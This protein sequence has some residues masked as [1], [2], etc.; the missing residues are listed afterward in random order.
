MIFLNPTILF[1]LLAASI[2]I[3]LHFLNLR[4]IKKVE[5]STLA[6]LKELQKSKIRK[7]KI[8]QLLLL[9][10]RILI[11]LFL[12]ASFARPTLESTSLGG[13]ASKAKTT[14]IFI[15]DNS[16]SMSVVNENGSYFNHAKEQ[17]K[18]IIPS[19]ESGDEL[20]LILTSDVNGKANLL[21][22]S[23]QIDAVEISNV[24]RPFVKSIIVAEEI[25]KKSDNF[26]KEIFIFS[27]FQQSTFLEKDSTNFKFSISDT[28]VYLS[29]YGGKNITNSSLSNTYFNNQI[30]ELNKEIN[31]TSEVKTTN[32][33]GSEQL[34]SL[35]FNGKRVA[36][37][38]IKSVKSQ[39]VYPNFQATIESTGLIEVLTE[40]EED[41]I[42]YD[43][44]YFSHFI[45]PDNI[46]L[47]IVRNNKKQ[48]GFIR[49]ALSTNRTVKFDEI[50]PSEFSNT[51]LGSYNSLIIVGAEVNRNSQELKN[52]LT[53]GG[54][55]LLFPKDNQLLSEIN[56]L[57]YALNLP[58]IKGIVELRNRSA[59]NEFE[60][61]DYEHPIFNGLFTESKSEVESPEIYKYLKFNTSN[62][63]RNIISLQDNS[64]F[65]SEYRVGKGKILFFGVSPTLVWSSFPVK[66]IFAPLINRSVSYLNSKVNSDEKIYAG[67]IIDVNISKRKSEQIEVVKP[68]KSREL[69]N[70]SFEANNYLKYN[71]SSMI[72]NYKF[73]SNNELLDVKSVNVNPSESEL[74]M[75]D[76]E[77]FNKKNKKNKKNNN[78]VVDISSDNYLQ[79]ITSSR[80]GSELWKIFLIIALL[81]AL[82][83]M[84]IA[85]SAKKD[86]VEL[87]N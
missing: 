67:D 21:E 51:N 82:V 31:V 28:K 38:N 35:F 53:D 25:L 55:V 40:I 33:K 66:N 20:F 57:T 62:N 36:Q 6:F 30:F 11:I 39:N 85:R 23:K 50:L 13:V 43:N 4:K 34:V 46:K 70:H 29:N 78:S 47:L 63:G 1:G 75:I 9:L 22:S 19:F 12:V 5:F 27:D 83:E 44:R 77:S 15:L 42:E 54:N 86:L 84:Y 60:K 61:I 69:I 45:V 41:L 7:I 37:K 76:L 14:A 79:K 3:V 8:K 58:K 64:S 49:A 80:Y 81:L 18:K 10:L 32:A 59:F 74:E 24:T 16:F 2:P 73:Y 71:N 72:G 68:D 17:I 52:Y 87:G 56:S 26:N 65:L 48:S